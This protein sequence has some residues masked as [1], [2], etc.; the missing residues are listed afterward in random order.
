MSHAA[1]NCATRGRDCFLLCHETR[2]TCVNTYSTQIR[3]NTHVYKLHTPCQRYFPTTMGC[4][5]V[6]SHKPVN[7]DEC[8]L[9]EY[10]IAY[11]SIPRC[12]N[13]R[14]GEHVHVRNANQIVCVAAQRSM[15]QNACPPQNML[16]RVY[17][18]HCAVTQLFN[19]LRH[20]L[21]TRYLPCRICTQVSCL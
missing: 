13:P 15:S 21:S 3:R 9:V 10:I 7:G 2:H 17:V 16:A 5:Y 19:L 14:L 8:C 20:R 6:N 12:V 18:P 4:A 1:A 11:R